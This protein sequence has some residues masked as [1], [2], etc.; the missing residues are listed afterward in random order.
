MVFWNDYW[1]DEVCMMSILRFKKKVILFLSFLVLVIF[2]AFKFQTTLPFLFLSLFLINNFFPDNWTFLKAFFFSIYLECLLIIILS[3]ILN[4]LNF[5][6]LILPYLV[7][8][9]SS[10]LFLL[11]KNH[12]KRKFFD[13][14][15]FFVLLGLLFLILSFLPSF[16]S[17]NNGFRLPILSV[18]C[19]AGAHFNMFKESVNLKGILYGSDVFSGFKYWVPWTQ[20]PFGFYIVGSVIYLSI[21]KTLDLV[22][23]TNFFSLYSLMVFVLLFIAVSYLLFYFFSK[24]NRDLFFVWLFTV[25]FLIPFLNNL[26]SFGFYPQILSS[27]FLVLIALVILDDCFCFDKKIFFILLLFMGISSSWYFNLPVAFFIIFAFVLRSRYLLSVRHYILFLI[28]PLYSLIPIYKSLS[29][30]DAVSVINAGGGVIKISFIF[31]FTAYFMLL[32]FF[33]KIYNK[34]GGLYKRSF[35]PIIDGVFS[36]TLFS[37]LVLIY[38]VLT[39]GG[40]N[41]FFYKSVYTLLIFLFLFVVYSF[42]YM[43]DS[44]ILKHKN[45]YLRC[46]CSISIFFC[47]FIISFETFNFSISNI[48][49]G[50]LFFLTKG[51]YNDLIFLAETRNDKNIDY[52]PTGLYDYQIWSFAYLGRIPKIYEDN[53]PISNFDLSDEFIQKYIVDYKGEQKIVL[54]DNKNSQFQSIKK[55]P[56]ETAELIKKKIEIYAGGQ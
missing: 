11:K 35:I 39:N 7:L 34:I 46:L 12:K 24:K 47:L 9:F 21:F 2:F 26:F 22:L 4:L 17:F 23:L 3:L 45:K 16:I 55:I 36:S 5:N 27:V 28:C 18:G 8:S 13:K 20:Y 41:Y 52:Y 49:K 53:Y 15:D 48:F 33:N 42:L 30:F 50:K 19:D 6:L 38:Q 56:E 43:M 32:F 51:E 14:V 29:S 1:Y 31:L 10:V 40:L 44:F 25:L 37:F 54:L